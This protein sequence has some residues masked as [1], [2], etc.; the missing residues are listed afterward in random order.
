MII[1]YIIGVN[2]FLSKDCHSLNKKHIDRFRYVNDKYDIFNSINFIKYKVPYWA[3][4]DYSF[5]FDEFFRFIKLIEDIIESGKLVL[6]NDFV[7]SE[8]YL[9]TIIKENNVFTV[10]IS[11]KYEDDNW[12]YISGINVLL[13]KISRIKR[14][15]ELRNKLSLKE[16]VTKVKKKI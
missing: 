5:E 11:K 15:E 16:E 13:D 2:E 10:F 7:C 6:S 1:D 3:Y 14:D 9:Y 4:D 12:F 8:E